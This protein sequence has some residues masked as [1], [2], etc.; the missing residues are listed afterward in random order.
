MFTRR[1]WA[2]LLILIC[3]FNAIGVSGAAYLSEKGQE[4][5]SMVSLPQTSY[6]DVQTTE[7]T[8]LALITH[9]H[10]TPSDHHGD[11]CGTQHA[12]CHQCHLGHC[13]FLVTAA[14]G[15]VGPDHT[16]LLQNRTS[17]SYLS[18]DLSGP[19]KPPRA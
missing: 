9:S 3:G 4:A 11:D 16:G 8:N 17:V 14:S 2:Y 5:T 19:R 6:Q 13:N 12:N 18:I 7:A 15:F 10:D 1:L